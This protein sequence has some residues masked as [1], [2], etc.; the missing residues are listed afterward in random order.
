M[1]GDDDD[2]ESIEREFKAWWESLPSSKPKGVCK[3]RQVM[4]WIKDFLVYMG[5]FV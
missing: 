1:K 4:E 2:W 5:S 3:Y